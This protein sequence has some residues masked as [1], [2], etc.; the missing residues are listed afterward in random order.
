MVYPSE[1]E[2]EGFHI[3][4][5]FIT[6]YFILALENTKRIKTKMTTAERK[7]K[8]RAKAQ[9]NMTVEENRNFKEKE[10]KRRPPLRK[11]QIAKMNKEECSHIR[12][13][14]VAW[15]TA[16]RKGKKQAKPVPPL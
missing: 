14:E 7:R 10:N 16:S 8:Q 13:K 1:V 12:A 15:V 4:N 2:I 11:L 5:T 3:L 9:V 6:F